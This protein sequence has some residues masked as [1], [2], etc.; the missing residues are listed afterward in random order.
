MASWVGC[1]SAEAEA[2]RHSTPCEEESSKSSYVG[3]GLRELALTALQELLCP[4]TCRQLA[5]P[6]LA[7]SVGVKADGVAAPTLS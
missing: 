3:S 6:T 1:Q 2:L 5:R 4:T 7:A